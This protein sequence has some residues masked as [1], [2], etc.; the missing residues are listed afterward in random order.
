LSESSSAAE[1]QGRSSQGSASNNPFEDEVEEEEQAGAN[2]FVASYHQPQPQEVRHSNAATPFD[3]DQQSDNGLSTPSTAPSGSEE[4]LEEET[5]EE[6]PLFHH[7]MMR[8]TLIQGLAPPSMLSPSHADAE[9]EEEEEEDDDAN[10]EEQEEEEANEPIVPHALSEDPDGEEGKDMFPSEDEVNRLAYRG[11][12]SHGTSNSSTGF[13]AAGSQADNEKELYY[14][15]SRSNGSDSVPRTRVSP[16]IVTSAV[17]TGSGAAGSESRRS[18][19]HSGGT[20]TGSG[21]AN[22]SVEPPDSDY[23]SNVPSSIWGTSFNTRR[24]VRIPLHSVSNDGAVASRGNEDDDGM[25]DAAHKPR[26]RCTLWVL[27]GVTVLLV[28]AV[29][30]V[31]L[32]MFGNK[33]PTL[34]E[35]MDAILFNVSD[36]TALQ[37]DRTPQAK[38]RNWLLNEDTLWNGASNLEAAG[39]TRQEVVQRYVLAVLYFST[40][41]PTSWG[42]NSG[43]LMG[44]ECGDPDSWYGLACNE[45]NEIQAVAF[46]TLT[47]SQ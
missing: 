2:P 30:A 9:E 44:G 38:A 10:E 42:D 28:G 11:Y 33:G 25:A 41:G 45:N 40:N 29:I 35:Q 39:I 3:D 32:L 18:S 24:S 20:T 1:P 4:V 5:I 13:S 15:S 6:H 8:G 27:V 22:A 26:G 34:D 46:G 12:Y 36:P 17:G 7:T 43:W 31:S 37:D 21:S 47:I 16:Y 23:A 14:Q 19:L